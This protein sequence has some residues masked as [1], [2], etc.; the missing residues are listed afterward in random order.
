MK[1]IF[2]L[3][4]FSF[5]VFAQTPLQFSKK[6]STQKLQTSF[7]DTIKILAIMVQFQQD[8]ENTTT[9]NGHFD[10]S[11]N[12]QKIIDAPPRDSAYFANHLLFAKNY[13]TKSSNGKQFVEATVLGNVIT[14]SQKMQEYSPTKNA[15]GLGN[16]IEESWKAADA[17]NPNFP[18]QN[19]NTFIIF[20]A[21]VGKDFDLRGLLGFDPT[22][23]DLPSLYFNL[24]GL[25]KIFGENYNGVQLSNNNIITNT[26]LL[27][28]T[29]NRTIN[30]NFL[31]FSINGLLV[32]NIASHLGLPDLFDTKTGRTAIGRFGLMDGQSMFSFFGLFP[33]EPSAWEKTF[34]GWTTPITIPYGTTTHSIP[35]VGL[36]RENDTI[37][38]IPISTK[39][40]FLLENRN[41]DPHKNGQTITFRWNGQE[42]Q[43]TFLKD[44]KNFGYKNILN[45][46]GEN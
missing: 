20:H 4:F 19:Y 21:G 36:Q 46:L 43:K 10:L 26:I 2:F 29:E 32:A 27:P 34:L 7:S 45:K 5:P 16:L 23:Y 15:N 44:E 9:G 41:R 28:E 35:A 18:F 13:Y 8:N 11:T 12:P 39:E 31:Q 22:P 1:K 25:K 6:F 30:D 33:P 17:Q 3:L 38:K 40:Y 37:Y 42:I 24:N 14:L